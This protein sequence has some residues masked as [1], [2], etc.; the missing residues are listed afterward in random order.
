MGK[1]SSDNVL[2]ANYEP[3]NVTEPMDELITLMYESRTKYN[4]TRWRLRAITP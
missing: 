2:P 1:W 4:K 3:K